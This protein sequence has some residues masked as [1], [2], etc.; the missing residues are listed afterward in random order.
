M[1]NWKDNAN[2]ISSVFT[3]YSNPINQYI[4]LFLKEGIVNV[5][6]KFRFMHLTKFIRYK[7][8]PDSNTIP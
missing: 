8:I 2:V 7:A 3:A 6:F 1:R 5:V 4:H